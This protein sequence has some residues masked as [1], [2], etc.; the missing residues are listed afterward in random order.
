MF[1]MFMFTIIVL[2][3]LLTSTRMEAPLGDIACL[4]LCWEIVP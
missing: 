1:V 4:L 3:W 2:L